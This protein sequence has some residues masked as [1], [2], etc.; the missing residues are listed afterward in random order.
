MHLLNQN[1]WFY[2]DV[3][4]ILDWPLL[5][6]D[7]D[8]FRDI[9]KPYLNFE[10]VKSYRKMKGICVNAINGHVDFLVEEAL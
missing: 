6:F 10:G 9:T 3:E 1:Y 8:G 7:K 4:E 5:N 2:E